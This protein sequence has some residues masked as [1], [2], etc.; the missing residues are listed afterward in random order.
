MNLP[1]KHKKLIFSTEPR[2]LTN[3]KNNG[4]PASRPR[5]PPKFLIIIEVLLLS[6]LHPFFPIEEPLLKITFISRVLY[7]I[8]HLSHYR[9]EQCSSQMGNSQN[10]QGHKSMNELVQIVLY[11]Y[12]F[13][14]EIWNG[15]Q[16][17]N[18]TWKSYKKK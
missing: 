13:Q 16:H 1:H 5:G 11:V 8:F 14:K 3:P 7:T 10:P 4:Y 15:T 9:T 2:K 6:S 18:A 17:T 12:F